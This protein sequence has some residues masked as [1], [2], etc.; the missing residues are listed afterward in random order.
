MLLVQETVHWLVEQLGF[1]HR[2]AFNDG[3]LH[4]TE[5]ASIAF[6]FLNVA[7]VILYAHSEQD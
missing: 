2:H 6:F 1:F 5:V 3:D 7:M 4:G